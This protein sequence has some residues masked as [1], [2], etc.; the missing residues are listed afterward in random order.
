M[1]YAWQA[2][3]P[4]GR[5]TQVGDTTLYSETQG[6]G[7]PVVLIHG[8]AGS[9]RWWAR[10]VGALAAHHELHMVDLAGC[11]R[12]AGRLVLTRATDQ[13][14]AWMQHV[15]LARASLIGHSMGGFIVACLAARSPSL[16][17]RLVLV[18]AALP[19]PGPVDRLPG[20]LRLP[21]PLSILPILLGDMARTGLDV[22]SRA[23]R[24]LVQAD[25]ALTLGRVLADTLL[26]W[27]EHDSMVPLGLA[28]A[29]MR[30]LPA[31][32]LAVICNAGH[33]PMWE[34]PEAFNQ[35]VLSFLA[36]APIT[37]EIPA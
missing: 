6:V 10:N 1:C 25:M 12:S 34:Q 8:L 22:V 18:N 26:I 35:T 15:G 9:S 24:E 23:A 20:R 11:G 5:Y 13:L 37:A 28:R 31:A 3:R 16:V 19:L 32:S 27:G 29:A 4:G 17:D 33:V 7:P 21:V 30:R 36:G 2:A 14:A